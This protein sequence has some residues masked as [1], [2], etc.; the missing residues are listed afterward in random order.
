M[1]VSFFTKLNKDTIFE[2]QNVWIVHFDAVF[3]I[4]PDFTGPTENRTFAN[5]TNN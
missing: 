2:H 1:F 5:T 3:K 4:I